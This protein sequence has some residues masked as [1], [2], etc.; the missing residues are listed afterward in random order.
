MARIQNAQDLQDRFNLVSTTYKEIEANPRE[1]ESTANTESFAFNADKSQIDIIRDFVIFKRKSNPVFYHY[2]Q[3][4]AF[5]EG[6][7]LLQ[8]KNSFPQRPLSVEIPTSRGTTGRLNGMTKVKTSFAISPKIKNIIYDI[9]YHKSDGTGKGYG[10][11]ELLEDIISELK[12]K[13]NWK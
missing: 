1:G 9:I 12:E 4:S 11:R 3:S 13:Y 10:K 2:N 5:R 7:E 8:E 6:I